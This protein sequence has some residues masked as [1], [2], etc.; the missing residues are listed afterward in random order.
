MGVET[1]CNDQGLAFSEETLKIQEPDP[2]GMSLVYLVRMILEESSSLE[3]LPHYFEKNPVVGA[4]GTIWSD[5]KSG[6]GLL[7]ELTPTAW[8]IIRLQGPLLWDFNHFYSDNLL[9][10]Q[11]QVNNLFPDPDRGNTCKRVS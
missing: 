8:N 5:R 4:Y 1:G 2:Q 11:S 7:A 6:E 3:V 10:Q 9:E